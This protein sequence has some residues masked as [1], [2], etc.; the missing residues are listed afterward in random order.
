MKVLAFGLSSDSG[1][2]SKKRKAGSVAQ[3]VSEADGMGADAISSRAVL[4]DPRQIAIGRIVR[5]A[6]STIPFRRR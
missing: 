3:N 1:D 4:R 6:G 5:N 2:E